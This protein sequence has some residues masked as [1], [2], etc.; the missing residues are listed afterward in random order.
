MLGR[1]H[2]RR[3]HDVARSHAGGGH[4]HRG[5]CYIG[6]WAVGQSVRQPIRHVAMVWRWWRLV[7]EDSKF[8][9]LGLE[10]FVA[11]GADLAIGAGFMRTAMSRNRVS[12]PSE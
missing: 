11:V 5:C 12:H 10:I 1:Y 9:L 8:V 3:S 4:S 7:V 6:H 2:L